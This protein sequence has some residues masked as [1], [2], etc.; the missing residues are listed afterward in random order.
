MT[1]KSQ[2]SIAAI[3]A[4]LSL[5][6]FAADAKPKRTAPALP[7][8]KVMACEGTA[9]TVVNNAMIGTSRSESNIGFGVRMNPAASELA[10]MGV[11][12]SKNIKA[13]RHLMQRDGSNYV[14]NIPW[15]DSNNVPQTLTM[16]FDRQGNF[17]GVTEE[18]VMK[19]PSA[20]LLCP[21]L[22]G[23]CEALQYSMKHEY[24]GVCWETK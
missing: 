1:R 3:F 16:L 23:Y 17:S 11:Q 15:T 12:G 22:G 7:A 24:A 2:I 5:S 6:A 10:I 13:G 14:V 19:N 8:V 4:A 9:S 20:D 18:S 21:F